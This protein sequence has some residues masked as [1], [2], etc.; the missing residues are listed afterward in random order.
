[1]AEESLNVPLMPLAV[2][3]DDED[4]ED[5]TGSGDNLLDTNSQTNMDIETKIAEFYEANPLFY[6]LGNPDYKNK[7]KKDH[8]LSKFAST[9]AWT[10]D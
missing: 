2:A 3:S 7:Q 1:M 9:I 10:G 6:D 4:A 5:H 8:L